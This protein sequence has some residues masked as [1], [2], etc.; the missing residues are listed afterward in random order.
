VAPGGGPLLGAE[1]AGDRFINRVR[2]KQP[3]TFAIQEDRAAAALRMFLAPEPGVEFPGGRDADTAR[4][5]PLGFDQGVARIRSERDEG[6][7]GIVFPDGLAVLGRPDVEEV[8]GVIWDP[9]WGGFRPVLEWR[10]R[11]R[12]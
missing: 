7:E 8:E 3:F 10:W 12:P 11:S 5:E 6:V 9:F 4:E 1:L 2:S